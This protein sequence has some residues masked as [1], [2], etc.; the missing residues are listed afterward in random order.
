M[1]QTYAPSL[2][3]DGSSIA[4]LV[5]EGGYPY[6]VR[7]TLDAG[8]LGVEREVGLPATGTGPVTRVLHSPDGEWI[9]CEVSPRGSERLTTWIVATDGASGTARMLHTSDDVKTTLVEWDGNRLA[10]DAVTADGIT[11]ARSV[12]PRSSTYRVLDRRTDSLLVAAEGGHALMRVGPRG[13]RELLLTTPDGRWLPLLPPDPGSMTER[14][15]ILPA[16][17]AGEDELAVIVCSDHGGDRQRI[18]R[19]GVTGEQVTATELI[20]S[21]EA[22][23]DEFVISEDCTTAAVLWNQAGVSALELLTLDEH[24][25]VLMRRPVEL[26][27]LVASDLTITGDGRLLALTVEGPNLPRSVEVMYTDIGQVDSLDPERAARLAERARASDLPELVHYT[28]RDGLELSGWL[29]RGY[30]PTE[31]A[32][33]AADPQPV[34]IHLHGGPEGQ[35]RP[36]DHDILTALTDS[37][38]TVFT[39]NIRGSKG[40]GRAFQ[41]AD[42]RYGRLAAVKDVVDTAQFLIDAGV[43]DPARISLGGRSYGGYLALLTGCLFPGLFAAVVDACGMTSFET[44]FAGTEPWLASAAYPKYGYPLHDRELLRQISP[45][46]LVEHLDSPVLF[47]HGDGDTNVPPTESGQMADALRARGVEPRVLIVE[48]EGHQFVRPESRRTIARTMLEFLGELGI[49]DRCDLSR[50]DD[51]GTRG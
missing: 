47:I 4:Y 34:H 25:A 6:A 26:P 14:G 27:G 32:E 48:G 2:A 11:E 3:P 35:S 17:G 9:A 46:N 10:M 29:Y 16:T 24:Q 36:V 33:G 42:D 12:D 23:V 18:L 5:R 7:C 43:A 1:R 19:L 38:V 41:H 30:G 21:P 28:A 50:F 22:D 49:A 37:G 45:L 8:G 13:S 39:P 44:Y 40:H 51:S 31:G 20:A 15:V